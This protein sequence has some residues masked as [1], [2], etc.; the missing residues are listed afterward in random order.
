MP[1]LDTYKK[2]RF[3]VTEYCRQ[4]SYT[5]ANDKYAKEFSG[6]P[7][8]C[9][10]TIFRLYK[11]LRFNACVEKRVVEHNCRGHSP[12]NIKINS[13]IMFK[14]HVAGCQKI[15]LLLIVLENIRFLINR[16]LN[17]GSVTASDAFTV[18]HHYCCNF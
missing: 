10:K 1:P 3:M 17:S 6:R 5:K 15:N 9:N 16:H 12:V 7:V 13:I 4:G 18:F 11:K 14:P 2:K 8:P